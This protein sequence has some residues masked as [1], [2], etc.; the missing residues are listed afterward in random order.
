MVGSYKSFGICGVNCFARNEVCLDAGLREEL[1]RRHFRHGLDN[2]GL[3]GCASDMLATFGHMAFGCCK[4][5]GKVLTNCGG[6]ESWEGCEVPAV[7]GFA[8]CV[9][10]WTPAGLVEVFDEL[11]DGSHGV[12][13]GSIV[14]VLWGRVCVGGGETCWV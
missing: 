14:V 9:N 3:K 11:R 13:A 1:L 12:D 6:R 8:P 2:V 5:W 7:D 10:R 4:G